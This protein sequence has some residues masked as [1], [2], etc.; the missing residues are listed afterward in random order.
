MGSKF[1]NARFHQLPAE[2]EQ[3]AHQF[4]K[5]DQPF[6]DNELLRAAKA[7]TLKTKRL[8]PAMADLDNSVLPAIAKLKDGSYVILVRVANPDSNG[9]QQAACWFTI[10]E[11]AVQKAWVWSQ[12]AP[13]G[14]VN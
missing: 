12:S 5:P 7:L 14:Q 2:P 4:G 9:E 3:I 11:K 13:S 1:S 6:S 8:K 10:F